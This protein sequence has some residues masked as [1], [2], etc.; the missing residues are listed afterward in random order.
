MGSR[1]GSA[2]SF[3][4]VDDIEGCDSLAFGVLGVGDSVTDDGLEEGLEDTTGLFV[5]HG[6]NTLDT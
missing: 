4:G 3:K 5:D 2:L 1:A 6:G